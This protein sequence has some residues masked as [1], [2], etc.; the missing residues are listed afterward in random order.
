MARS[1]LKCPS[2]GWNGSRPGRISDHFTYLE[3]VISIRNVIG[4]RAGGVL[5]VEARERTAVEEAAE[6]PWLGC[7]DCVH[8]FPIPKGTK[9]EF[10]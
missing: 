8:E 2:C 4:L 5:E 10:S 9:I 6:G 7:G 1:R 3:K